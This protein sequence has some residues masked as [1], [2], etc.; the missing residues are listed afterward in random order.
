MLKERC[1]TLTEEVESGRPQERQILEFARGQARRD[2]ETGKL[3]KQVEKL[4]SQLQEAFKDV[5]SHRNAENALRKVVASLQRI[6][7]VE[8]VNMTYLRNVVLKYLCFRPESMERLRLVPVLASM[9]NFSKKELSRMEGASASMVK[10]W[11]KTA[12]EL[13][14]EALRQDRKRQKQSLST[15]NGSSVEVS[16][17][18]MGFLRSPAN[19]GSSE[20]MARAR[21]ERKKMKEQVKMKED[22]ALELPESGLNLQPEEQDPRS[23]LQ[24][25]DS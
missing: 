23:L 10:Q 17:V 4:Q 15:S 5:E 2:A 18:G 7:V 16:A 19:R 20:N 21:R 13:R 6:S 25:M 3:K 14:Q 12:G 24:P 9:L 22:L 1:E 8:G 11:W